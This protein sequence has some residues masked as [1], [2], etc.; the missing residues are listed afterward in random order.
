MVAA[1][2]D[3]DSLVVSMRA[4]LKQKRAE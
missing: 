3:D 2:P 1:C 4:Y